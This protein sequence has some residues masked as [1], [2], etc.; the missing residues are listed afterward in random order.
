MA[1]IYFVLDKKMCS[2]V[3]LICGIF[4]DRLSLVIYKKMVDYLRITG[5]FTWWIAIKVKLIFVVQFVSVK[6]CT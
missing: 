4:V 1:I 5:M 2:V 3:L 6:L